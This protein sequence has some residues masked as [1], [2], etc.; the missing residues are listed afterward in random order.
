MTSVWVDTDMGFDDLWALLLLRHLGCDVA[1]VSLVMGNAP[2]E[3]VASNAIGARLAYGF[4]WPIWQGAELP[5]NKRAETAAAVLGPTGMR[6]RGRQLER[7]GQ[8]M[9][10]K[11]ALAA[12]QAWLED[13][14]SVSREILALGPLTNI[15]LLLKVQPDLP[16]CVER[17]VWMGGSTGAGNHTPAAEFNAYIDALAL[18]RVIASGIRLDIVDL[19][20]CR[21][22]TFGPGDMPDTDPLTHDLLGGYLD[23]ALGRGRDEMAVY[24]PVAALAMADPASVAF[25]P[26]KVDVDIAET[27]AHG[28]TVIVP[29]DVS[30]VRYAVG[31]AEGLAATCLSVLKGG[32]LNG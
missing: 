6:T 7:R 9:P 31:S 21:Q 18:A 8:D 10:P 2:M 12:M 17:I 24:D 4:D 5:L 23:I 27:D 25:Q 32:T 3:E 19:M 14:G 13:T 30:P 1:G 16:R 22:V 20:F 15:A 29:A 11:G 28:A 26:C